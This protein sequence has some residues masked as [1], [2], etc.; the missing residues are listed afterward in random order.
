MNIPVEQPQI[1]STISQELFA[2]GAVKNKV[3]DMVARVEQYFSEKDISFLTENQ[4]L[5][6][7]I[8]AKTLNLRDYSDLRNVPIYVPPGLK[9]DY[10]EY[11]KILL[12]SSKMCLRTKDYVVTPYARWLSTNINDPKNLLSGRGGDMRNF[13]PNNLDTQY[14]QL[15]KA[16]KM[17]NNT[18][19]GKFGEYFNRNLAVKEA[20]ELDKQ[21]NTNLLSIDRKEIVS[22]VNELTYYL[23]KL[24]EVLGKMDENDISTKTGEVLSKLTYTVAREI[25]FIGVTFYNYGSY[26]RALELTLNNL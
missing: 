3:V 8:K 23:E 10:V 14:E 5:P 26:N 17:G 19:R 4:F 25:E 7:S 2:Y 16:F 20:L 12:E 15:S 11:G 9:I 22:K 1:Q 6:N 24:R 21:I 18:N 13:E